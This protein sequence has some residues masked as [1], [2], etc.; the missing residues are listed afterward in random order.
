MTACAD[1]LSARDRETIVAAEMKYLPAAVYAD[2]PL[3]AP[4]MDVGAAMASLGRRLRTTSRAFRLFNSVAG[5]LRAKLR[6]A[7]NGG[8]H[9]GVCAVCAKAPYLGKPWRLVEKLKKVDGWSKDG[10]VC[11]NC[12]K[13]VTASVV[14]DLARVGADL[15]RGA[16]DRNGA[17][18]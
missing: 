6:Q 3:I 5:R 18:V 14:G 12:R 17:R 11:L 9:S 15:P 7:D 1:R 10:R 8:R 2:G 4:L 13:T 16:D